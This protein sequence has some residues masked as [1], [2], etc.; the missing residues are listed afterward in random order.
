VNY[1]FILGPIAIGWALVISLLGL[2][3]RDFPGK[4]MPVV[5][6]ISAVLFLGGIVAAATGSKHKTGER[7][8]PPEGTPVAGHNNN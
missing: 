1:F 5:M 3:R 4:A 6:A 2:T 8:G 7:H